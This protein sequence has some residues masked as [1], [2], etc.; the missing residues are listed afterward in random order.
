M[1]LPWWIFDESR[2]VPGTTPR[3][4]SAAVAIAAGAAD[5]PVGEV[6]ECSGPLYHR[7]VHPLLLAALNI[8]PREGSAALA[9]AVVR[10]TLA[11][12]G[13]A[14]RPLIARDGLGPAFIEPAIGHLQ[15][16]GTSRCGSEHE[17]R[18]LRFAGGRVAAL[19]FGTEI[20]RAR[21]PATR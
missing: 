11:P 12:G 20:T 21:R 18:A 1:G 6:I 4:I 7:L 17:L 2:R 3:R 5:A 19:D 8:E 13:K 15:R 10:E 14:C 16:R 9:S